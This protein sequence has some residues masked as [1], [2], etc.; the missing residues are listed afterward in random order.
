MLPHPRFYQTARPWQQRDIPDCLWPSDNE[1][2]IPVL[3]SD[4]Q[5][6]AI[7]VPVVQWGSRKRSAHMFGTW[8][9]YVDDYKFNHLWKDSSAILNSGCVN[10]AEVN[11]SV[12]DQLPYALALY[13]TYRK[14]WLARLWQ[15]LAG[16]RIFVDLNVGT[17]HADTNLLGVPG[18]WRAYATRGYG[19]RLDELA[20]ELAMA[21]T[22]RGST[23]VLFMV[24]GGGKAVREWCQGHTGVVWVPE[25]QLVMTSPDRARRLPAESLSML[26][27]P[28]GYLTQED[29]DHEV[30]V[31]QTLSTR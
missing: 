15:E 1:A 8:T 31:G 20:M 4:L 5:A 27:L 14:R 12:S 10:A 21:I 22:H 25:Q 26:D 29:V 3:R 11:F 28:A 6:D 23:D 19:D 24:Y 9:F 18:G 7:D 17:R 30:Q 13:H 16:I 2:E